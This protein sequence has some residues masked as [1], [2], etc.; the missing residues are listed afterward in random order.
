MKKR[1]KIALLNADYDGF[2]RTGAFEPLL[3]YLELKREEVDVSTS[4]T[5]DSSENLEQLCNEYEPG[6]LVVK[7]EDVEKYQFPENVKCVTFGEGVK[8]KEI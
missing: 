6:V 8:F 4:L 5:P 2:T 3:L 1:T 7:P